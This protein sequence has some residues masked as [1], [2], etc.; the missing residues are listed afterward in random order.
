MPV[1]SLVNDGTDAMFSTATVAVVFLAG[2]SFVQANFGRNSATQAAE[3]RLAQGRLP[4]PYARR[5][6][7]TDLAPQMRL[8]P[9]RPTND[10]SLVSPNHRRIIAD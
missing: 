4:V 2:T 1:V 9:Y 3:P 10:S 6:L 8:W 5:K 7:P